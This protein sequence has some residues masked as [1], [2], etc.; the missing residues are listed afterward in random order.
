MYKL[1]LGSIFKL[2]YFLVKRGEQN[3]LYKALFLVEGDPKY[4]PD[5]N[6]SEQKSGTRQVNDDY[7]KHI[8]AI[9]IEEL[10]SEYRK[11]LPRFIK[12][13][14]RIPVILALKKIVESDE[15]LNGVEIGKPQYK[16]ELFLKATTFDFYDVL[17]SFIYYCCW[18]NSNE[19]AKYVKKVEKK[20]LD[21]TDAEKK[22][23]RLKSDTIIEIPTPISLSA[24]SDDFAKTFKEVKPGGYFVE[25]NALS[26][27][28]LFRLNTANN[29]FRID[30]LEDFLGNQIDHYLIPRARWK[31]LVDERKTGQIIKESKK[32]LNGMDPQEVF[33]QLMLY[34]F[35]ECALKA[36]KIFNAIDK[37][38][39]FGEP[40][41]SAGTYF[42]P[43][44]TIENDEHNHL[45]YG[46]CKVE[47][48]LLLGLDNA[49]AQSNNIISD[50]S[51]ERNS[52]ER[53]LIDQTTANTLFSDEEIQ[54]LKKVIIPSEKDDGEFAID[55][56]GIFV[57]YS[58]DALSKLKSLPF[59]EANK[60]LDS[61]LD[62]EILG[63]LP[64]LKE[65]LGQYK[66]ENKDIF[67][68]F[69][70]LEKATQDS[71]NVIKSLKESI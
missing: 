37:L 58:T 62:N 26:N 34:S 57:C 12:K 3:G 22:T 41:K 59:S 21:F 55:S 33:S 4:L 29:R 68:F 32:V 47:D 71:N 64:H 48:N 65:L 16:K 63:C 5:N 53:Y 10:T 44:G 13:E 7:V 25:T 27:I 15:T 70:P 46:S 28:R 54:F 43:K 52:I 56:L 9:G 35:M 8:K 24:I 50:L 2:L 36:P 14:M 1:C 45:V 42:I 51:H 60:L 67:L 30:T 40:Q 66:L 31:K 61:G 17:A 23:I 20:L 69:L 39:R 6:I 19:Y 11:N 38:D 18:I 49:I